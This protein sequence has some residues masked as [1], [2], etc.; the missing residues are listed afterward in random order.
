MA[1]FEQH[2]AREGA[3]IFEF[4]LRLSDEER[5]AMLPLREGSVGEVGRDPPR[6]HL[7]G[8]ACRRARSPRATG[9]GAWP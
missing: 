9:L 4:F 3:V 2:L 7:G 8:S 1:S 6:W 5:D